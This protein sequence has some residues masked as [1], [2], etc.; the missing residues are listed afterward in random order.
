[1]TIESDIL[2]NSG[3]NLCT[4]ILLGVFYI[5]YQRCLTCNSSCHTGFFDCTSEEVR[6]ARTENKI[7]ILMKALQRHE[8][9]RGENLV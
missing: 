4:V 2:I 9:I 3:G 7:G 6:N 1:M 8:T 5:F